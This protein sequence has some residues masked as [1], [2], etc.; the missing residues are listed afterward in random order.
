MA[1]T[2]NTDSDFLSELA[3]L[4]ECLETPVVPGELPTWLQTVREQSYKFGKLLGREV[5]EKHAPLLEEMFRQDPELGQRVEDLKESDKSLLADW[6]NLHLRLDQLFNKAERAEPNE[7]SL[8]EE[9]KRFTEKA[10]GFVVQT[11]KQDK[12]LT[13]WYMEAFTRDRGIAD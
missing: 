5:N 4:E 1:T 2:P 6:S 8:D 10:L 12:A 9:I 3:R 7:V 13:T 11:R